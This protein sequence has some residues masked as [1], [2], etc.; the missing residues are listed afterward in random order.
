MVRL[1]ASTRGHS[2][3]Y[4]RAGIWAASADRVRLDS[5]R[6]K[7]PAPDC[8]VSNWYYKTCAF[9]PPG[10]AAAGVHREQLVAEDR[11]VPPLLYE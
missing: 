8:H 3:V 10:P 2:F 6:R 5:S 9:W 4:P 7:Q 1:R 11:A